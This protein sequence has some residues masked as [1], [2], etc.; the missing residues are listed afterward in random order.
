MQ[1]EYIH[2]DRLEKRAKLVTLMSNESGGVPLKLSNW[3]Y[4]G[5]YLKPYSSSK[6]DVLFSHTLKSFHFLKTNLGKKISTALIYV[7][8]IRIVL[9]KLFRDPYPGIFRQCALMAG[10]YIL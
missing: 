8:N 4:V 3:G 6:Q 10:H 2:T 5:Q 7:T 9:V 1:I